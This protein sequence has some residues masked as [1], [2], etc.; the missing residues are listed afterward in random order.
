MEIKDT[1]TADD[2]I[3]LCA[4]CPP[5]EIFSGNMEGNIAFTL[6]LFLPFDRRLPSLGQYKNVRKA[7][8]RQQR[9]KEFIDW[10]ETGKIDLRVNTVVVKKDIALINASTFLKK[11]KIIATDFPLTQMMSVNGIEITYGKLLCLTWYVICLYAY[12]NFALTIAGLARKS[13]VFVLLDLLTGDN[14]HFQKN[15]AIIDYIAKT[16]EL[17]QHNKKELLDRGVTRFGYGYAHGIDHV[18]YDLIKDSH[19]LCMTDWICRS[20]FDKFSPVVDSNISNLCDYLIAK[21][22]LHVRKDFILI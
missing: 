19:E 20:V 21:E 9:V 7:K 5:S 17:S 22:K 3:L 12:S 1:L 4:D 18:K 2:T 13:Q 11:N 16:S 8:R 10:I 15:L 14:D 6:V